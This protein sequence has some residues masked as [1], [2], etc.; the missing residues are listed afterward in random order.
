[1]TIGD[2]LAA[3]EYV[4]VCF[5]VIDSRIENWRIKLPDTVADNGSSSR[6]L[7]GTKRCKPAELALESA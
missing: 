2:V 7:L 3:T 6:V 1:V 4:C 5:E